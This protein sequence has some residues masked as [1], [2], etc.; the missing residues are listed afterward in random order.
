M[1]ARCLFPSSARV[2]L[3][4]MCLSERLYYCD[5][6][7]F[8]IFASVVSSLACCEAWKGKG[9]RELKLVSEV[10]VISLVVG[11]SFPLIMSSIYGFRAYSSTVCRRPFLSFLLDLLGL[12]DDSLIRS[13]SICLKSFSLATTSLA[14]LT[15]AASL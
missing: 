14:P 6:L 8:S 2:I 12:N 5:S 15:S 9:L 3:S 11:V 7:A 10:V 1:S 13:A 4:E